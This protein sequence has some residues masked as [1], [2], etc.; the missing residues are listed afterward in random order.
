MVEVN[1]MGWLDVDEDS[2]VLMVLR[3]LSLS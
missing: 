3:V 1:I 2:P